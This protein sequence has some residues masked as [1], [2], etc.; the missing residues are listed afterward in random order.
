M[1]KSDKMGIPCLEK[2]KG[3]VAYSFQQ[4]TPRP[5]NETARNKIKIAIPDP[6]LII[7]SFVYSIFLITFLTFFYAEIQ[8]SS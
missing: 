5:N 8:Q 1:I 4:L 7:N 6:L 2:I 3:F